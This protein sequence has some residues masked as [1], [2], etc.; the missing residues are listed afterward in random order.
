MKIAVLDRKIVIK[1]FNHLYKKVTVFLGKP[2]GQIYSNLMID[3]IQTVEI[4]RGQ[5]NLSQNCITECGEEIGCCHPGQA[6]TCFHTKKINKS[7]TC[8]FGCESH[9]A[10]CINAEIMTTNTLFIAAGFDALTQTASS[11]SSFVF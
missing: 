2:R 11:I 8:F 4:V 10:M 5:D 1:I 7:E 3:Q 6:S 9:F